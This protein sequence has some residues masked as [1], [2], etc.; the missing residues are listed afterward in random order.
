MLLLAESE[1]IL[2][3][4]NLVDRKVRS[5]VEVLLLVDVLDPLVEIVPV[6]PLEGLQQLALVAG[7]LLDHEHGQD[8][9]CKG[10]HFEADDGC[11]TLIKKGGHAV[12]ETLDELV[13]EVLEAADEHREVGEEEVVQVVEQGVLSIVILYVQHHARDQPGVGG[14]LRNAVVLVLVPVLL[15]RQ[16]DQLS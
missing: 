2:A 14:V 15:P 12:L 1:G 6:E 4:E 5:Y 8:D 11:Y 10:Q 3:D 16:S 7:H 13:P 9:H